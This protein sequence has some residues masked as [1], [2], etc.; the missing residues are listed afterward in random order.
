MADEPEEDILELGDE[1][2]IDPPEGGDDTQPA[3]DTNDELEIPTFG[4]LDEEDEGDT[5]LIRKV[6][7]RNRELAAKVRELE[8]GKKPAVEPEI[9]VGEKPTLETC[10]WDEEKFEA[11]LD[12]W[13]E[14]KRKA[15]EQAAKQTDQQRQANEQWQGT[16][17]NYA[18][19]RQAFPAEVM[20]EAESAVATTLSPVQQAIIVSVA[21]NPAKLMLALGRNQAKL[22]AIATTSDPLKFAAL[23]AKLE[24]EVK[25]TKRRTTA[26]PDTPVRGSAATS[27]TSGDK[28]LERLEKEARRTGDRSKLVAYKAQ[29]KAA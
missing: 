18:Q 23:V 24:T 2:R 4:D 5:D 14:R 21:D 28:E 16:L 10:E 3:A 13:K 1:D 8:N 9:I 19:K 17:S 25:M 26:E 11:Q 20:D 27:I 22:D 29:K 12:A 7:E 15:E 6:R